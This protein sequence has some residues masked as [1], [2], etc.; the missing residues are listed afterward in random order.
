M[1][2]EI[3]VNLTKWRAAHNSKAENVRKRGFV[4]YKILWGELMGGFRLAS[5]L[6]AALLVAPLGQP[7]AEASVL[8]HLKMW[9]RFGRIFFDFKLWVNPNRCQGDPERVAAEKQRLL[10]G[11]K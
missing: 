5:Q 10:V 2:C 11:L 7:K 9:L 3:K 8:K 1:V 4:D 6:A